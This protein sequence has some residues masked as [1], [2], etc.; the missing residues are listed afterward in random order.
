MAGFG[1][2]YVIGDG[3]GFMGQDGVNPIAL[4]ILVGDSDRQWLQ[5]HYFD[6]SIRPLGKLDVIIPA[7]PYHPDTLIDAC[8]AFFPDP[9]RE[10]P[11]FAAVERQVG[12]TERLDF[13]LEP[14]AIPADWAK[15]REEARPILPTI[16]IWE[17]ELV[18]VS[19]EPL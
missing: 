13:D 6:A 15:L 1:K 4:Q 19:H 2:L 3:G 14:D 11:S 17:A 8:I 16:G 18:P 5:P 7:G 9:F 10:C 12:D